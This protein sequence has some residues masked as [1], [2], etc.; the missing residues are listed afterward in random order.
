MTRTRRLSALLSICA[1]LGALASLS[2]HADDAFCATAEQRRAVA[3]FYETRP[4]APPPIAERMLNMPEQTVVSALPP[5]RAVMSSGE[6]FD[7]I[8]QS[9]THWEGWATFILTRSGS[10]FKF[11]SPVSKPQANVRGDAFYDVKPVERGAGLDGHLRVDLVRAIGA[12]KLPGRG[13]M[14]R[15]ILFY[16]A[17][18]QAVFGVYASIAGEGTT[19]ARIEEFERTWALL[20][21]LPAFCGNPSR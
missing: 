16:D 8:W 12:V 5:D 4:G 20:A 11:P 10:L 15:A 19:P 13:E 6:H 21:S 2:A 3:K 1:A 17:A 14:T 7:A 9:M 18:G